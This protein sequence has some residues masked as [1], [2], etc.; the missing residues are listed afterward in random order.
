MVKLIIFPCFWVGSL[1][2]PSCWLIQG[3]PVVNVY[4]TIEKKKSW[5][6][7]LFTYGHGFNVANCQSL[8]KRLSILG[9]PNPKSLS[10][11]NY[12]SKSGWWFGTWN[13]WLSIQLGIRWTTDALIFFRQV[14][15]N[16]QPIPMIFQWYSN[17]IPMILQWYSNDIPAMF[18]L[19]EGKRIQSIDHHNPWAVNLVLDQTFHDLAYFPSLKLQ[20]I[21]GDC[22]IN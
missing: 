2:E 6:N 20:K 7:K 15:W 3:Y 14:G 10:L 18:L 22:T 21:I 12:H 4:I 8:R 13:L 5:V 19:P 16:H 17:D 1:K 9:S 11:V